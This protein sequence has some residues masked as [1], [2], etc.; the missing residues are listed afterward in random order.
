MPAVRSVAVEAVIAA[1]KGE[2]RQSG[3]HFRFVIARVRR[4]IR[5]WLHGLR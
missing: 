4:W 1:S 2:P 5:R 3:N